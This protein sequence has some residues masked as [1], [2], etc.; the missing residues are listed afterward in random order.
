MRFKGLDL[1]LLIALDVLLEERSVSRTAERL[2]LSQPAVSAA[3]KRLR[4][5]FND[6][7]LVQHGKQM[8]PTPLA[9]SL[10]SEL[11][12]ILADLDQ[13]VTASASFNPKTTQR[14]FVVCASDYINL[15]LFVP[16]AQQLRREAPDLVL[17]I[18]PPADDIH[19]L[20]GRG[21]IDFAL[22]PEQLLREDFY[23]EFLFEERFVLAGCA[24]NPL[25]QGP[26]EEAAFFKA[27]QVVVKLGQ[28]NPI[29][30]SDRDLEQQHKNLQTDIFITSFPMAPEMVINTDRVTIMH[31][32]LARIFVDRL[33]LKVQPLPFELAPL[34][35]FFQCHPSRLQDAGMNWLLQLIK[36]ALILK[37]NTNQ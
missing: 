34:K 37:K 3:L 35:E 21:Q 11:A 31:E 14:K 19:D 1:N 4:E 18:V 32:R 36:N 25:L 13:F 16:L 20:M 33:P 10:R 9:L 27:R 24:S 17:E 29:S 28:R 22:L 23:S 12:S 5:Y 30:I 2:F 8:V 26:V 6:P 7:I 15:V